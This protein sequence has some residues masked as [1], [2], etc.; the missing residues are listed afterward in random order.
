MK[1]FFLFSILFSITAFAQNPSELIL[2]GDLDN[3][4]LRS[5]CEH[6]VLDYYSGIYHRTFKAANNTFLNNFIGRKNTFAHALGA[7][8]IAFLQ[9]SF[10]TN[11]YIADRI[12]ER[13]GQSKEEVYR[14]YIVLLRTG[15]LCKDMGADYK[16]PR[17][18][19]KYLLDQLK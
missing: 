2:D 10:T 8:K 11:N 9:L 6:K 4:E 16:K 14:K 12:V 3:K 1:S 7:P 13:S 15:Q 18:V 5:A 19:R 17:K